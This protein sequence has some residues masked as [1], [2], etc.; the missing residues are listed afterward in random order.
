M[1]GG[2]GGCSIGSVVSDQERNLAWGL[3]VFT[4]AGV[5]LQED[6]GKGCTPPESPALALTLRCYRSPCG[7]DHLSRGRPGMWMEKLNGKC[8]VRI[9]EDFC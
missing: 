1:G 7:V 3:R 6:E 9:W 5:P 8:L 4:A 2:G